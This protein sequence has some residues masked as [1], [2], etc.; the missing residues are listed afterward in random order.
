MPA[1][2]H[3]R[4]AHIILHSQRGVPLVCDLLDGHFTVVEHHETDKLEAD[5]F[6]YA[7]THYVVALPDAWLAVPTLA[8]MGGLRAELQIRTTAQHIWAAASHVF[9]YKH[10]SSVPFPVRRPLHR[11]AALLE[12][13]DSEFD[14]VLEQR[15]IYRKSIGPYS[16]TEELNV[17]LL[18]HI[19]DEYLPKA[20][21]ERD[22]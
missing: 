17:D 3:S 7:S 11:V 19:L 2:G 5:R 14:R 1:L 10:E 12:T 9:Q 18:E 4:R 16:P 20:N 8:S 22:E 6:G 15:D 21:K 13:V